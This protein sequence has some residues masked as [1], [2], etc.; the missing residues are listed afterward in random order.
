MTVDGELITQFGPEAREASIASILESLMK[1]H[2]LDVEELYIRWEQFSYQRHEKQT[3]LN[4]KNLD[5]FKEFLQQQIEKKAL[6]VS[7]AS[8]KTGPMKKNKVVRGSTNNSAFGFSIPNTPTIKKR[9]LQ[10]SSS[11]KKENGHENSLHFSEGTSVERTQQLGSS[12]LL[13]SDA[14]RDVG[15]ITPIKLRESGKILDSL[16]PENIEIAGGIDPNVETA[17]KVSIAPYFDAKKYKFRTMRQKIQ[18]AADVLDEQIEAFHELIKG[19]YKLSTTDFADPTVQSQSEIYAIGRVVPDS[20]LSE[21]FPNIDAIALETSRNQGI[22]RRIRLDLEHVSET[23]LFLGQIVAIKGKNATGEYFKVEEVLSLPYP[24]SPVS[25][26][27]EIQEVQLSMDNAPMKAVITAGPY[28]ADDKWDFSI[29]SDFVDRINSD[30]KPHTIVMFGPFL[31]ITQS[32]IKEANIPQFPNMKTQPK[33]LD[34]V[35]YKVVVPILKRIDSNIQVVLLP[36]TRDV[37]S[38]HA[39]YPQDSFDR[40][41]LQLPRNFKCFPNPSTF[42]LNEVFVGCS[43]VDIYKDMKEITKGGSTSMR[44][45]FDRVSEHVLQQRRYYPVF[46]GGLKKSLKFKDKT[47]KNIYEH[48]SGAD[49]DVPYLPLTEFV[50][51]FAP[52]IIVIPSELQHFARVVRNVVFI[53]PGRFVLPKGVNGTFVQLTV[54]CPDIE[55]GDLTRIED[56]EPTFLHNVWKRSRVDIL[57]S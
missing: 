23:S 27:N 6:Q 16:N 1:L 21:G 56:D 50:G 46:P 37:L 3:D 7:S 22:G 8:R 13:N 36:S 43:N 45:R 35:F 11:T 2:S 4:L 39:A 34:E 33:T 19:H 5:S 25:T 53:N 57:T 31:D 51:C 41:M 47:G 42:Q 18:D 9:K 55:S 30:I 20:A 26:A 54:N 14:N 15:V 40:K 10:V 28:T 48:I 44:N 12:P 29:L 17:T 32:C 24:D 38:R 52:D 49:L